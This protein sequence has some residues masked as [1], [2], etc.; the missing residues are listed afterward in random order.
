MQPFFSG[1]V[2]MVVNLIKSG[3]DFSFMNYGIQVYPSFSLVMAIDFNTWLESL[4]NK[5]LKLL[6]LLCF[7]LLMQGIHA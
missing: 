3:Q 6:V 1:L 5:F 4:M 7:S 2:M